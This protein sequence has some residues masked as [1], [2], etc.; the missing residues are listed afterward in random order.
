MRTDYVY[1]FSMKMPL[2]FV[3]GDNVV[4]LKAPTTVKQVDWS[5]ETTENFVEFDR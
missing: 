2:V 4:Q 1:G 3:R 5:S